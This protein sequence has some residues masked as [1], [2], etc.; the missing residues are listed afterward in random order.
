[1]LEK[2]FKSG[3]DDYITKPFDSDELLLR[4]E[5]I[6]RRLDSKKTECI[7]SLCHDKEHKRILY[8]GQEL[9]LSK[10]EYQLLLLLMQ[11]A[12]HAVPKE[13][14]FNELWAPN[15]TGSDGAIRVYI[16]RIKQL[17][18]IQIDNI[19]GIGYKLVS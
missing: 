11:H 10:K 12:N 8:Q 18:P 2:G 6:F 3:G 15:E 19:R 5:A 7:D 14:I 4:I 1:M 13:L 16:N 17:V 9:E